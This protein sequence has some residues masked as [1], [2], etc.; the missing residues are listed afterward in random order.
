FDPAGNAVKT[1]YDQQNAYH[2]KLRTLL[3]MIA[4]DVPVNMINAGMSGDTAEGGLKRLARDVL[5]HQP[6]VCVVC[7]GL[8]DICQGEAHLPVY[9]EA[10][11]DIFHA[12]VEHGVEPL[13][14]TPNMMAVELSPHLD[15]RILETG[16][17]QRIQAAF[18][19]LGDR[20]MDAARD[21]CK[22][23]NVPVCDCYAKWKQLRALGLDTDDLLSNY[24]NHPTRDMHWLFAWEL[25]QALM[26]EAV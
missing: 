26:F 13:F 12:L 3:A 15:P 6:D 14:M 4:P 11:R 10:L 9:V 21:V 24:L 20:Y 7:F 8:N 17:P 25:F 16:V 2:A 22:A 1:L 5:T 23:C 18:A 19:A